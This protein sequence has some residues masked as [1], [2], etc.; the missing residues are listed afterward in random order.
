ML[1]S[2]MVC[3]EPFTLSRTMIGYLTRPDT[4]LVYLDVA[5]V[6]HTLYVLHALLLPVCGVSVVRFPHPH[7]F[8]RHGLSFELLLKPAVE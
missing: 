1:I 4:N 8:D 3:W 5:G 7:F 2:A 6:V